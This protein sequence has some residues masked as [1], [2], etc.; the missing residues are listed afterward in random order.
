MIARAT[1]SVTRFL[2][3]SLEDVR[4]VEVTKV[5]QIDADKGLWEVEARVHVP[6]AT[7]RALGLPVRREVLES[8]DYILRLG[9]DMEIVA[10][11][12]RASID[13]RSQ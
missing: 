7:I 6:N 3:E 9:R 2:T 13:V 12:L 10:F 5:V 8:R 4:R 1:G 11:G